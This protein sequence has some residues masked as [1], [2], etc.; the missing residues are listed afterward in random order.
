MLDSATLTD[1]AV[2]NLPSRNLE[3]TEAFYAR[4]GFVTVFR[5]DGWMIL[6]RGSVQLEFFLW[7]ALDPS[8]SAARFGDV[9]ELAAM[10]VA[11]GI[12]ITDRGF[13]RFHLLTLIEQR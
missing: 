7:A 12:T 6:H 4:L 13:P 1:R 5:D 9:D 8:R 11:A 10:I 3:S 2:P